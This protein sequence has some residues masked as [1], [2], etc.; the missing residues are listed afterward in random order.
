MKA[1]ARVVREAV[2]S[3]QRR[4]G[5]PESLGNVMRGLY[6]NTEYQLKMRDGLSE[7]Y[8][9]ERGFKEGCPSAPAGFNIFHASAM[10]DFKMQAR[11]Q[12][13]TGIEC[14][15][16]PENYEFG[17]LRQGT[18]RRERI[19][20]ET[21]AESLIHIFEIMFADVTNKSQH[22]GVEKLSEKVL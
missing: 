5:V 4:L 9:L 21:P 15:P 11:E 7:S 18:E 10:H 2:Y 8:T 20:Q 19:R 3:N 16:F 1:Y 6:E 13:Y 22:E 12:G 17:S 14:L